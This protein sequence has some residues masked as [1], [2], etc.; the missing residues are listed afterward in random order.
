MALLENIFH[1]HKFYI[2]L[3]FWGTYFSLFMLFYIFREQ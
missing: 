2:K 3:T 1:A